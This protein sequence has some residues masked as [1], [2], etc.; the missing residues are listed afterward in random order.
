MP[1]AVTAPAVSRFRALALAVVLIAA[2]GGVTAG[3]DQDWQPETPAPPMPEKYDWIQLTSDEW[4]KGEFIVMYDDELEFDSDE[5]DLQ[6]F[7]LED[8][9]EVRTAQVMQVGLES[10][11]LLIGKLFIDGEVVRVMGEQ[12]RRIRRTEILSITAGAPKEINFW[13]GKVTLGLNVRRGN[14]DVIE[15]N[16]SAKFRRRTVR[17]RVV[18]DYLG[19]YNLAEE[20]LS[21]NNHRASLVWD[22]FLN[23]R[24][25]VKPGYFEW[26][27]D[28]FQ[29]ISHRETVGFG[30]GYE[31]L[32]TPKHDW[33]ISGGPAYQQTTF[34]SVEAGTPDAES[35]PAFVFGSA[36][37]IELTDWLDYMWQ[38]RIQIVNEISGKYNHHFVMGF[39]TEVTRLLDFDIKMIWD[40]IQNPRPA[41]DESVPLQDDYRLV[42]GLVFDW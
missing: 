1:P 3:D 23:R 15:A 9:R 13:S 7:D 17:N 34:E 39:E 35:T 22:R 26:F 2:A 30:A 10:G 40:R 41:E 14:S 19:T 31:L 28:P 27:K 21:S 38:Y 5:M 11:E 8:V 42:V 25:F 24:L 36:L 37:D 18:I 29:N 6:Q 4:L 16:G 20:I 33:T 12:D 32:D